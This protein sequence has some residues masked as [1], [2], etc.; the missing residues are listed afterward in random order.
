MSRLSIFIT[1]P[2]ERLHELGF[3]RANPLHLLCW[4]LLK[5]LFLFSLGM[6]EYIYIYY[7]TPLP[8]NLANKQATS[9]QASTSPFS[10]GHCSASSLRALLYPSHP[11]V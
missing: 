2:M 9:K 4:S 8:L 6:L 11:G 5:G 10:F 7:Y 3:K 1:W